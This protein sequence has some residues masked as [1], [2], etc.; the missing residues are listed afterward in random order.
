MK[1]ILHGIHVLILTHSST[2]SPKLMLYLYGP[3]YPPNWNPAPG[4]KGCRNG[5]ECNHCHLCPA[6]ESK[7]RRQAKMAAWRTGTSGG[8]ARRFWLVIDEL[9]GCDCL[10]Q[11]SDL[12][13][14]KR[15]KRWRP[16][17]PL[18]SL[19]ISS[20]AL[21][22]QQ[23]SRPYYLTKLHL[24][25]A[26][27]PVSWRPPPGLEQDDHAPAAPPAPPSMPPP[28]APPVSAMPAVPLGSVGS[29]KHNTGAAWR[30]AWKV[31]KR[32]SQTWGAS[33]CYITL[34]TIQNKQNPKTWDF[35]R[36]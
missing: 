6:G 18:S 28:P 30:E 13:I 34:Q 5:A 10:I 33:M 1:C 23:N 36:W 4:R 21:N 19:S 35:Y 7:S 11:L 16:V 2:Q 24:I 15:Y 20:F 27:E 14:D 3:T 26:Q 32:P 22:V 25:R 31:L 9:P 17:V 12:M 29:A 8:E